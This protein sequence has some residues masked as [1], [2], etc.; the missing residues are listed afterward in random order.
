L[1]HRFISHNAFT[2][3][4][5]TS[6]CSLANA[7]GQSQCSVGNDLV[8]SD[9]RNCDDVGVNLVTKC[10]A[11][12]PTC[13]E[14]ATTP[15]VTCTF[16]VDNALEAFFINGVNRWDDVACLNGNT[17]CKTNWRNPCTIS[18]DDT[19]FTEDQVIAFNGKDEHASATHNF[20]GTRRAA[21]VLLMCNSTNPAS[22][23]NT[24]QSTTATGTTSWESYSSSS[25]APP[26][27]S[28][29]ETA[30]F[31]GSPAWNPAQQTG[32]AF[33]CAAC[34]LD[35]ATGPRTLSK[36]WADGCNRYGYFRK[37]LPKVC[38][39]TQ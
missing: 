2:G 14:P 6:F 29:Y 34:D 8:F 32:S 5:P 7:V 15:T 25:A 28:G 33:N 27:A 35:G 39:A 18:F 31:V 9:C 26:A 1:S 23:W 30:A 16:S 21:G 19:S 37:V 3:A 38:L 22:P 36:M 20:C 10:R 12:C 4:V 24:V 17:D 13:L 11:P